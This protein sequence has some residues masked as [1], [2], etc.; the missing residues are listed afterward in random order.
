MTVSKKKKKYSIWFH[1]IIIF[2]IR[3]EFEFR[4]EITAIR[5][6]R[7]RSESFFVD[8]RWKLNG[9]TAYGLGVRIRGANCT[10]V[11]SHYTIRVLL[12]FKTTFTRISRVLYDMI[13]VTRK[14][15]ILHN[16]EIRHLL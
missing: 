9:T 2:H 8:N 4:P 14:Y 11:I 3:L 12:P 13:D 1:V 16:I 7:L 15:E 10:F 5:N 6:I